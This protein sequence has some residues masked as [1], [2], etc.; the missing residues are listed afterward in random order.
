MVLLLLIF[1]WIGTRVIRMKVINIGNLFYLI[2]YS[3]MYAKQPLAVILPHQCASFLS[4]FQ[5]YEKLNTVKL[6]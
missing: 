5:Q 1:P 6:G 4:G 3:H 2:V